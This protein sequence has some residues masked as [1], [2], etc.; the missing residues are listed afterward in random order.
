MEVCQIAQVLRDKPFIAGT[1]LDG[2][3][4][5]DQRFADQ[6][7][8]EV[9]ALG[10]HA[11]HGQIRHRGARGLKALVAACRHFAGCA[12]SLPV[13]R[14]RLFELLV[15]LERPTHAVEQLVKF[16]CVGLRVFGR[17]T[18]CDSER[19]PESRL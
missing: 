14:L 15:F 3:L 7:F 5:C 10:L 19:L 12:D 2:R 4:K 16:G 8:G 9:D 17:K 11:Q 13:H 18:P 6:L 1:P